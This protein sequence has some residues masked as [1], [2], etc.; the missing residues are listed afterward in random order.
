M[1]G[2]GYIRLNKI[3]SKSSSPPKHI[4]FDVFLFRAILWGAVLF[5]VAMVVAYNVATRL[6]ELDAAPVSPVII[7]VAIILLLCWWTTDVAPK[8]ARWS[9]LIL[10][11]LGSLAS[12]P[13]VVLA[14]IWNRIEAVGL[15]AYFSVLEFVVIRQLLALR[16]LA[17]ASNDEQQTVA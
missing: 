6:F 17:S 9:V 8:F 15:I 14:P 16:K 13:A 1:M 12:I 7:P 3:L 4:N 5:I 11:T 2:T 10:V